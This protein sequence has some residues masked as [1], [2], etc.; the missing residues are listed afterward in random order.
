MF[1]NIL[2]STMTP[3]ESTNEISLFNKKAPATIIGVLLFAVVGSALYDFLIK[4]GINIFSNTLFNFLTFGSQSIK[5]YSFNT[6]ALDP[7]SMP[8]LVLLIIFSSFFISLPLTRLL[9]RKIRDNNKCFFCNQKF[10]FK[11]IVIPSLLLF[12]LSI[13]FIPLNIFNQAILIWR[14]F[15]ADIEI[16]AP[17]LTEK[18]ILTFK[19]QFSSIENEYDYD[20][21]YLEINKIAYIKKIKL[22]NE[23]AW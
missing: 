12:Q 10:I 2:R 19:S 13:I 15:H 4:P 11:W 3:N 18:E 21:L 1:K 17:V 14:I 9:R 20:A 5:D 6:A 7:T 8:S 22:R 23:K 16:L